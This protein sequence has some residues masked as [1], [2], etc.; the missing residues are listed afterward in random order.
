LKA[1]IVLLNI[2]FF[3]FFV[4]ILFSLKLPRIGVSYNSTEV[5]VLDPLT[6]T[7]NFTFTTCLKDVGDTFIANVTVINVTKLFSWQLN[8]TWD[9]SMLDLLSMTLPPDHVFSGWMYY[10]APASPDINHTAGYV[11]WSVLSGSGEPSFNGTGTLAQLEFNITHAPNLG[12]TIAC[13]I[14]I[15]TEGRFNSYLLDPNVNEIPFTPVDGNYKY[16]GVVCERNVAILNVTLSKTLIGQ[17][18]CMDVN[19]TIENRGNSTGNFNVTVYANTTIIAYLLENITLAANKAI[20]VTC[21]W[22]TTGFNKGNY[23]ISVYIPPVSNETELTDNIFVDGHVYVGCFCD[24]DANG[25]VEAKDIALI[26]NA[27]GKTEKSSGWYAPTWYANYDVDCNG[28]VEAKDIAYAIA[29]YG[30]KGC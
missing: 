23:T 10:T 20:T 30:N 25:K 18:R 24:V 26:I 29:N 22:N 21:T 15:D 2:F 11:V 6:G 1:K 7:N 16:I 28:K 12:E 8:I 14:T 3:S 4:T 19:V 13:T 5:V 9:P 17:G 27:Y